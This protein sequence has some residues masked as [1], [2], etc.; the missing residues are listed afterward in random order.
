MAIRKM[1]VPA[2]AFAPFL[3][4]ASAVAGPERVEFPKDWEQ[5]YTFAATRDMHRGG[6]TIV[7]IFVN[8]AAVASGRGDGPLGSGSKIVMKGTRAKLDANGQP[9]LDDKGRMI[10]DTASGAITVM[11]KRAGWGA[12]NPPDLRNGDW[13]YA[14]FGADGVRGTGSTQSC[15]ECHGAL[16]EL[17]YVFTRLEISEIKR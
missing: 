1:L 13:E 6:N 10:K 14:T 15:F 8:A 5:T 3:I 17:D 16:E 4:V 7:D 2:L 11:E 12:D 9:L